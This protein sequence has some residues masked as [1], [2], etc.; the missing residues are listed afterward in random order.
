MNSIEDMVTVTTKCQLRDNE[1]GLGK[2][3]QG[4]KVK[5]NA[6]WQKT[7]MHTL[8]RPIMQATKEKGNGRSRV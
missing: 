6:I 3:F 8:Q 7:R 1:N 2:A 4:I 5:T